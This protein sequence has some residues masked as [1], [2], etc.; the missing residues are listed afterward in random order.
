MITLT[1]ES[2][3]HLLDTVRIRESLTD[4]V[5]I[6]IIDALRSPATK[7]R[8]PEAWLD[9]VE[10]EVRELREALQST[11]P[12]EIT[13]ELGDVLGNIIG[14]CLSLHTRGINPADALSAMGNKLYSRKPWLMGCE[15]VPS[16]PE[17]EERRYQENKEQEK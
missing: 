4:A 8:T 11:I 17:E 10:E 9:F 14:L 1:E 13:T 16:T 7:E 15:K 3:Q 2:L 6:R 12:H 5:I